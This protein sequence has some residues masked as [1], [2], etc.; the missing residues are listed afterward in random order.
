MGKIRI[1]AEVVD[2]ARKIQ[3]DYGLTYQAAIRQAKEIYKDKIKEV[4][5]PTDQDK[6]H[7]QKVYKEILTLKKSIGK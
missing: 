7:E 5:D 2:E 4:H 3:Q 1:Y 6:D